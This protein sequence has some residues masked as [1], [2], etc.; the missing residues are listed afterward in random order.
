M[1]KVRQLPHACSAVLDDKQLLAE[2]L[3]AAGTAQIAPRTWP[4]ACAFLRQHDH[5]VRSSGGGGGDE[6]GIAAAA[7][8]DAAVAAPV[9][10]SDAEHQLYFLKHRHGVKVGWMAAELDEG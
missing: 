1:P 5:S 3:Q 2:A 7:A 8:C 9:G 10:A 6:S 4:D